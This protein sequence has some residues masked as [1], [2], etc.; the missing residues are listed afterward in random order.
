MTQ[1][2]NDASRVV[3]IVEC[4]VAVVGG[5]PAGIA[6]A[7]RAAE[8]GA[9]TVVI[10]QGVHLGGQIWRH[11]READLPRLA[12]QWIERLGRS[13][14]R[15][16]SQA[17]VTDATPDGVLRVV[18]DSQSMI[19]RAGAVVVA[20]GAREL[21]IPYPGWTLP[22]VMGIGGGQALLKGG[23][24]VRGKRVIVAGSGPLI[25]PVAAAMAGSGARLQAVLEQAP[26][27]RLASFG[28]SLLRHPSKM[29]DGA[30]YRATFA[31][32]A[33]RTGSWIARAEG[34]GRV[35]RVVMTDGRRSWSTGCDLLCCSYGLIPNVD[36]ASLLGCA[37]EQGRV[38][39]DGRQ[40]TSLPGIYAAG[41][42]T[43]I[44]GELAALIEG[45]IAGLA[46]VGR[47]LSGEPTLVRARSHWLEFADRLAIFFAPRD[48]LCHLAEP[49][50]IICRC[51]DVSRSRL[52]PTW[53]VRQAKLYTRTGMGPCQGGVCGPACQFLFGW[54]ADR[55]RPP[56]GAPEVG[57]VMAVAAASR[58]VGPPAS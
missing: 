58:S 31:R 14:A 48:E 47:D 36:L 25:L 57:A 15:V 32:T 35:G 54:P 21:F 30:R 56:L 28:A 6:A 18:R 55:V 42:P 49:D 37:V 39:V 46:A 27:G 24:N 1:I 23:M 34:N 7:V 50:T 53:T 8:S 12:R 13:G 20:T 33:Y 9:S 51:E 22:G 5:G 17:S 10:D 2:E 19:V 29:M 45:Q 41:E 11:Q 26:L 52:D 43:G 3:E 16:L 44:A 38:V 4:D 40:Q